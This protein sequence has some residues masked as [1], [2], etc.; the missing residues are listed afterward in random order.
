[1]GFIWGAE[2][3]DHCWIEEAPWS[4]MLCFKKARDACRIAGDTRYESILGAHLGKQLMNL[5][6]HAEALAEMRSTLAF[7]EGL[8]ETVTVANAQAYLARMLACRAPL[9][10][11]DEPERLAREILAA[12]NIALTG[13]AHGLLAEIMRRKGELE[14][15][16]AEARLA[17]DTSL[18]FP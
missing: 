7:A 3:F 2:A 6:A 9:A 13:W 1:W 8:S 11:L 5:G 10:E 12:K 4:A 16:E 14:G 15:A 17:I 18:P